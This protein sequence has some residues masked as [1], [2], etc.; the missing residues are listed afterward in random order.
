GAGGDSFSTATASSSGVGH[1][2][3]VD[4]LAGWFG[5]ASGGGVS[6][7]NSSVGGAGG[8]A[9]SVS[10]GTASGN[11][12]VNVFDRAWSGSGGSVNSGTGSGGASGTANSSATG[13]NAGTANVAV[14]AQAS[15]NTGGTGR[16]SGESGGMGGTAIAS[17]TG[18]GGGFVNTTATATGGNAG[19]GLN[20]ASL[21]LGGNAFAAA[22][23]TGTSGT[24]TA[25]A[26]VGQSNDN[27]VN[28]LATTA[29]APVA[30]TSAA[31]ARALLS[32]A[33]FDVTAASGQQATALGYGAPADVVSLPL[34]LGDSVHANF[35]ISAI[36]QSHDINDSG[37]LD[38]DVFGIGVLG[39][40]YSENG[41]GT[42][43]TYTSR[44]DFDVDLGQFQAGNQNLLVGFMNP[45][46]TGDAFDDPDFSVRFRVFKEGTGINNT[47]VDET[48]TTLSA[49]LAY[50][51]NN[52]IDLGDVETGVSGDLDLRIQLDVTS[53]TPGTGFAMDY[54]VGNSTVTARAV[55][56]VPNTTV[57]FGDYHV[58]D[59]TL[60]GVEVLNAAVSGSD[61]AGAVFSGTTGD[62]ITNGGSIDGL[63]AGASDGSSMQV[64]IDTSTAGA[65]TGIATIELTTDGSVSGTAEVFGSADITVLNG[66]VYRL[67]DAAIDTGQ[68]VAFGNV[69]VGDTVAP[70]FLAFSNDAAADGFSENLNA[71]VG[72]TTGGVIAEGSFTGL[73]ALQDSVSDISVGIDTTTAGDKSGVASIDFVSDGE[74]INSLGQTDLASQNVQ[75]TGAVY[76]LAEATIDNVLDFDFGNVQVG[77]TLSQALSISNTALGDGFSEA[78]N[79]SFGNITDARITSNGGTISLLAAGATDDTS[80]VLGIDTSSS[81]NVNGIATINFAS[82][83]EGSSGLGITGLPSQD[84]TVIANISMTAFNLADPVINNAQPLVFGNFREGDAVAAQ[85]LSITNDAPD[86]GFSEALD[87]AANGTTGGVTAAGSFDLLAAQATNDTDIS[88]SIDTS[89][90]GD[91]SGVATIDFASNGEGTSGLGITPLASQD[92]DVT[93]AV[94]R[95][96]EG[97]AT[98]DPIDFGNVRLNDST[99]QALTVANIAAADGY[100]EGLGVNAGDTGDATVSGAVAGLIAAGADDS[101][102]SVVLDTSVVGN[103]AGTVDLAFTSDGEG[104]SGFAAIDAG[105]QSI[106]VL[107]TVFRLADGQATPDPIDFG[108]VRLNDIIDQALTVAN[109]AAADGFS[110]GLGVGAGA[111]GDATVSGA[112]AGLI[113]AGA[114]DSNLSVGLDTSAV[115]SRAG[116]VELAFT[117]DGEGTSGL[118]AI[119][120]GGQSINVLGTVFRLADG[121]ATPDPID[122]GNVHL[123][124]VVNQALTVAN[125]AAADGFSESLGVMAGDTGDATVSGAVAGLI[126]AGAED[127][128][129]SV[130]L[131][132]SAAGSR[133]GTVE[134]TYNSDGEG[135]SGLAAIGAG[136]Q[137][138][139]VTG[140]VY[141]LAEATIDNVLDFDFGNVQVGATLSQALS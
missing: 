88:V 11:S 44:A 82:D 121:Q 85:L 119:D 38:S 8:N 39:G 20:G 122:F 113:A 46:V 22:T 96:A 15:G 140:A 106:D 118:A 130:A 91:K 9:T 137:T 124:D 51:D 4:G 63:A 19:N 101:G 37:Q 34:V 56:Y 127:S 108:N 132:T 116:T 103:R 30:S 61:N 57:N 43:R 104:T 54:V 13:S 84:L 33:G 109:I 2:V 79:A 26:T 23:G 98:P 112:V 60:Q 28:D 128:G 3:D 114:D 55:P 87:A 102:L 134:L 95:L 76:R 49:A 72:G 86:D 40:S 27:L 16:G 6:S 10:T 35:D 36:A 47:I 71:S 138:V 90:A 1:N 7:G 31:L 69:H 97:Q 5:N 25:N 74:G 133:A 21:G 99:N 141:R 24:T 67:A 111:T 135:T 29:S 45:V 50:F 136:G 66:K 107:G 58:G 64:G 41:S 17:A 123:N 80:M 139:E 110:E 14:T 62:A 125:L 48:F 78:L 92:V 89:T 131:D 73:G 59:A 120:A 129:L 115:G 77:A 53:D 81:G 42:S 68:P 75:V 100:S 93:G 83:G 65:K 52:T 126:A 117:S 94:F 12:N 32:G 18:S 70:Q 105:A